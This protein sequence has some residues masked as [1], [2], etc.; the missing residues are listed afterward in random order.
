MFGQ[1]LEQRALNFSMVSRYCTVSGFP[2][3]QP[4][5]KVYFKKYFAYRESE[6]EDNREEGSL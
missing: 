1:M 2:I 4:A 3:S 6:E 5:V